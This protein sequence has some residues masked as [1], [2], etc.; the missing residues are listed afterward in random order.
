MQVSAYWTLLDPRL[1]P[2]VQ[3]NRGVYYASNWVT[4]GNGHDLSCLSGMACANAIGATTLFVLGS[5]GGNGKR[6]LDP[7][8][9]QYGT[10]T[11]IGY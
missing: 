2:L 6:K 4:L 11:S 3:G 9:E 5:L 7:W 8:G 10:A 1:M